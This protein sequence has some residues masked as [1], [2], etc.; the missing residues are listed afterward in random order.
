[1]AKIVVILG[2][3][4][5][6]GSVLDTLATLALLQH[7][8]D[9]LLIT[10]EKNDD[11]ISA[12]FIVNALTKVKHKAITGFSDSLSLKKDFDCYRSLKKILKKAL[13]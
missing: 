4:V 7:D 6:G 2:R 10:G 3:L 11:E 5:V 9:I 12:G 8:H 13:L 1:M